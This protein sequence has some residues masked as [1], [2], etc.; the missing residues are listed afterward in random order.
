MDPV[1]LACI[2]DW[3]APSTLQQLWSF[4][5]FGN[6]Y[7]KFIHHYSD[8]THPLNELLQKDQGYDWTPIRQLAF[9]KL[10]QCFMEEPVLLLPDQTQPFQIESD[11]SKYASGA[12]LMQTNING[13]RHPCA[14]MSE[15]F[16]PSEWNYEVYDREFLG[17]IRALW[18]WWH[19]VQGYPHETIVY[20]DHKNLTYFWNPQKLNRWQA[21]W[22][23]ELSEYD[24]KL[25]HL[26]GTKMV[27]SDTLSCRSDFYLDEDN[28]NEDVTL[29]PDNLFVNLIDID[30]QRRIAASD[31]YDWTA[32]DTIKILQADGPT[33]A[34]TDFSDWAVDHVDDKPI[35]FYCD[36]CYVPSV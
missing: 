18:D 13:D 4:L 25:V 29:L 8:L 31:S 2:A 26:P 35:L 16:S 28:D 33:E 20:S 19:Y 22:S 1:K 12:V 6:F 21:G 30:L 5:G 3:P 17:I 14:Y 11:T 23:L 9:D 34:Q 27:Q 10:K 32:A 7:R 24:L 15:S 36:K